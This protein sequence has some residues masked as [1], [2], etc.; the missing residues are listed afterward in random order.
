MASALLQPTWPR[1][2]LRGSARKGTQP[3]AVLVAATSEIMFIARKQ[4]LLTQF[5]KFGVDDQ[6]TIIPI[7]KRS[8]GHA[9]KSSTE[10]RPL[11]IPLKSQLASH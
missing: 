4:S 11:Q 8:K 2:G 5:L 9:A 10:Y 1:W 6:G 7:L 3:G